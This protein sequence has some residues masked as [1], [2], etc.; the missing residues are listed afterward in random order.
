VYS[1]GVTL[2]HIAVGRLPFE[3]SSDADVLRMQVQQALSAPE[4]KGRGFS[5]HLSYF[6]EKMMAKE[7]DVRYQSWSELLQDVREQLQGREKLDFTKGE[8]S[9][10]ARPA[11]RPRRRF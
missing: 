4:L 8:A 11:P 5:P 3:S 9:A 10:P 6:I 2:F 7:A 1:L